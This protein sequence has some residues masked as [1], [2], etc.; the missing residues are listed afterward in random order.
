MDQ[1]QQKTVNQMSPQERLEAMGNVLDKLADLPGG[2]VKCGLIWV[3][4]ELI[5][6][7]K[8]DIET[9]Q[10]KTEFSIHMMDE[11]GNDLE[12]EESDETRQ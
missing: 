8:E 5:G 6:G 4:N 1:N 9:L 11:D 12:V 3:M 10:K 2:R 7:L